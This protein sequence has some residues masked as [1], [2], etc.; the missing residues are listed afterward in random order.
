MFKMTFYYI[1]VISR[2]SDY[3]WRKSEYITKI[4]DFP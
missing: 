3:W 4:S 1:S 2:L